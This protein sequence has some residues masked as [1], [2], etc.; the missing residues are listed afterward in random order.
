[1]F[2]HMSV[3]ARGMDVWFIF[4][5]MT[6]SVSGKRSEAQ[7][8]PDF[9]PYMQGMNN[10]SW[11]PCEQWHICVRMM[12]QA[13][14]LAWVIS[15][16]QFTTLN[17]RHVLH[18]QN[19]K[20]V[21]GPTLE[22]VFFSGLQNLGPHGFKYSLIYTWSFMIIYSNFEIVTNV[23]SVPP[24]KWKWP[25]HIFLLNRLLA[26]CVDGR[27]VLTFLAVTSSSM[28]HPVGPYIHRLPWR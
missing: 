21:S 13:S 8:P 26:W 3:M 10:A 1:M 17:H 25:G 12:M 22:I 15:W 4:L 27:D 7:L 6:E 16:G 9:S 23:V 19:M 18:G 2:A 5:H 11:Q 20:Y 14:E 28:S 24:W